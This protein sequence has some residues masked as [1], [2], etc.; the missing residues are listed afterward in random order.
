MAFIY[1]RIIFTEFYLAK[2][3][4]KQCVNNKSTKVAEEEKRWKDGGRKMF[5]GDRSDNNI[6]YQLT[7]NIQY[8]WIFNHNAL[9]LRSIC[10][11]VVSMATPQH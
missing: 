2:T 9:L 8:F 5:L 6:W 7:H 1:F 4:A 3:P 11:L 10:F